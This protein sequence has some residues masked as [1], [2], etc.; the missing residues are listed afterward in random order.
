MKKSIFIIL[1][2]GFIQV[3]FTGNQYLELR[4]NGMIFSLELLSSDDLE[5]NDTLLVKYTVKNETNKAVAILDL[6][7]PGKDP[8][9]CI[10]ADDNF[11]RIDIELGASSLVW[12]FG[13]V[14]KLMKL[15]SGEEFSII[16]RLPVTTI[17]NNFSKIH[18]VQDSLKAGKTFKL[19]N[20]D[21]PII[22]YIAYSASPEIL[23]GDY[24]EALSFE[25]YFGYI[26]KDV[27]Y[28]KI[29]DLMTRLIVEGLTFTLN[30]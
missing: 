28:Y 19:Q 20:L 18:W 23:E 29:D 7:I 1:A 22:A 6:A 10:Y 3:G 26:E 8:Y 13:T 15:E 30:I 25:D 2:L 5:K 27:D 4:R 12:E 17:W 16:L 9:N 21:I 24:S 14:S 11:I